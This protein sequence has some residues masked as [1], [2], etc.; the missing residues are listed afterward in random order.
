MNRVAMIVLVVAAVV[1]AVVGCGDFQQ[2][3][4]QVETR[5]SDAEDA[6]KIAQQAA[7]LNTVRILELEDRIETLEQWLEELTH[8][9][10]T[11]T[12]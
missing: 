9:A 8:D 11:E 12:R 7:A 5:I 4:A 10:G 1:F 3:A 6:A 2:R